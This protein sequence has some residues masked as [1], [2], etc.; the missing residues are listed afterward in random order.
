MA[1]RDVHPRR[2]DALIGV[3]PALLRP[4]G[5]RRAVV[6]LLVLA[7]TWLVLLAPTPASLVPVAWPASGLVAGLLLGSPGRR[8]APLAAAALVAMVAAQALQGVDPLVALALAVVTVVEAA[9]VSHLL[10]G[11][12]GGTPTLLVEGDVSRMVLSIAA[13]SAVAAAGYAVVDLAGGHGDAR[14]G[15]AAAF[16]THAASL[17]V[18][19]P[20]FLR[21]S[22]FPALA[23]PSER[24]AQWVVAVGGAAVIFASSD[25]PPLVFVLMPMFAWLGFRGTLREAGGVLLVV[26]GVATTTTALGVGPVAALT[27]RYGLPDEL[28]STYLQVFLLDCGL[29]L[30]PLAVAVA[31]QRENATAV[32]R[33]RDTLARIVDSATGTAIVATDLAGRVTIFNPGAEAI[34]GHRSSDVIGTLADDL[35][36]PG[37]HADRDPR[38]GP[39]PDAGF[40]DACRDLV[41]RDSPRTPWQLARPDGDVRTLLMTVTAVRETDGEVSG[42][43]ATGEDVTERERARAALEQALDDREASLQ[44]LSDLDKIRADLLSTVS[45]ELRTPITS[46]LGYTEMLADGVAGDLTPS[47]DAL[48]DRVSGNSHRLLALV[49]N[50]ITLSKAESGEL[51]SRSLACD[52]G[53]VVRTACDA[54]R[55]SAEKRGIELAVAVAEDACDLRGDPD[56]LERLFDNL[57]TNA[58]KCTEPGGRVDV[59]LRSEPG[60]ARVSVADTGIGI[61]ADEQHDVFNRFVRS[62]PARSREIQGTGLGLSIVREIVDLHGGTVRLTSTLGIG[63]RVEVELPCAG[64]DA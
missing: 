43:L 55:A 44:R 37:H 60:L 21:T 29:L 36:A 53:G 19:L 26:A 5:R 48:L 59:A 40:A 25:V 42:Y 46:I 9:V 18:L 34:L 23:P 57:L 17:M 3:V 33:G 16:G 28:V 49:E 14:L 1:A 15:A 6:L 31:Q 41:R 62:S 24:V 38:L 8:R 12:D 30:L 47:Q 52:L 10:T 50:L 64:G 27:T 13:G 4:A 56:Q 7:L 22:D 35:L 51:T 39:A 20:V 11:A 45:H 32:A 2:V 63:T 58:I 54:V 61:P